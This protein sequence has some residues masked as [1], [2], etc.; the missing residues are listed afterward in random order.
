MTYSVN[1]VPKIN[2]KSYT[3]AKMVNNIAYRN[4]NHTFLGEPTF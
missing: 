1:W 4:G 2:S 3:I